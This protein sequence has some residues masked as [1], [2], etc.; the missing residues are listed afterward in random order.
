[1][2]RSFAQSRA[3]ITRFQYLVLCCCVVFGQS[4]AAGAWTPQ[5]GRA[6][7]IVSASI[8]QTPVADAA[9]TTDLYYERGLG[10]GWAL[11][12]SPSVSDQDNIFARNEAQIAIRRSLYE[13]GVWAVST[14]IGAYIWKEEA[15][16]DASNGLEWRLAAGRSFGQAGWIDIETAV[17]DCLGVRSVRWEGTLGYG[18][19]TH[20]KAIIK[21]FGDSEGCAANVSRVQASYVYGLSQSLGLELGIR[22]TLPNEAQ[23]S[24]TGLVVGVWLRF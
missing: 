7:A 17:R 11:V 13:N 5:K 9:I 24:E 23:W 1:V 8:S 21:V 18:L 2:A 14:Q 12:L 10:R 19:R 16:Q 6:N 20:D 4:A 15:T 22:Q 3:S